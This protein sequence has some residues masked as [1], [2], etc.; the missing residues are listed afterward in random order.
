MKIIFKCSLFLLILIIILAGLSKITIPKNNT[1]EAGMERKRVLAK[2]IHVEPQNTIDV[3][4]AGDSESY[5]SFVPLEL[6][7]KYGFTSF[8]CGSPAQPLVLT[9]SFI[10]DALEI[11]SPKIVVH[12]ADNLYKKNGLKGVIKETSNRVFP[13]FQYHDRW[14]SLNKEDFYANVSYTQKQTNKGYYYSDKIKKTK[15]KKYM[16]KS[17]NK[18]NLSIINKMYLKKI[19]K[20]CDSKGITLIMYNAP[21]PANWNY[22]KHNGVEHL[23]KELNIEYIDLNLLTKELKIDWKKDSQ[24][25]K[26][27]HLNY[28]GAMKVTNYLGDYLHNKYM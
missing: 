16:K 23:A 19:K 21:T 17:K 13:V 2:G 24:D 4:V 15:K 25:K 14:K 26:G 9:Y 6:W 5:S 3:L 11:Q 27:E 1:E 28:N 12:E 7:N 8:V 20:L 10:K 18:E 22:E